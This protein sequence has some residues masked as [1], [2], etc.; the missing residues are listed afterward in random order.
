M[1]VEDEMT[2]LWDRLDL[3][4]RKSLSEL[5]SDLNWVRRGGRLALHAPR[6]EDIAPGDWEALQAASAAS[7]WHT[8][9]HQLRLCGALIPVHDLARLRAETWSTLG[10]PRIAR[11]FQ[12]FPRLSSETSKSTGSGP[13]GRIGFGKPKKRI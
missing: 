6:L 9:L 7:N 2:E 12:E 4:Q 8:F 10:E 3:A 13:R 11:V 1:R 5:R